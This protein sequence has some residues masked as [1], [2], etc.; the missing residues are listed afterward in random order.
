MS[1]C[2]SYTILGL[3]LLSPTPAGFLL[4]PSSSARSLIPALHYR[5]ELSAPRNLL[6]SFCKASRVSGPGE[7][8]PL[9]PRSSDVVAVT[10]TWPRCHHPL[11]QPRP[12][13]FVEQFAFCFPSQCR[14]LGT[15][16]DHLVAANHFQSPGKGTGSEEEN[17]KAGNGACCLALLALDPATHR[18]LCVDL[19]LHSQIP[20][21]HLCKWIW[22][23][24]VWIHPCTH[25]S[26]HA[27][28]DLSM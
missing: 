6:S 18:S 8:I 3:S 16:M 10:H 9:V 21:S 27:H 14:E 22:F 2:N 26:D 25:G 15:A 28:M 24:H 23:V 5:D 12:T 17:P 1:R 13:V 4:S 19:S 7:Q 20:S 11:L